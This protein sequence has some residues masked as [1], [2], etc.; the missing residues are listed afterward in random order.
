MVSSSEPRLTLVTLCQGLD[1]QRMLFEFKQSESA[2]DK[3]QSVSI[4]LTA[5]AHGLSSTKIA[6]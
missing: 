3:K 5:P 1:L 4:F 2:Y 6:S